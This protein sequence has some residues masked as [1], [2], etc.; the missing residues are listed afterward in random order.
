M[1]TWSF[2]STSEEETERLGEFV[3]QSLQP[4]CVVT[5]S[6]N[7]GAGKTRLVQAIAAGLGADR[8]TVNS[9]TFVL[10]QEYAG[11]MPIYHFDTYRL[12]DVDEF[13]ALGADELLAGDGVCLIEWGERVAEILPDDRLEITIETTGPMS[14]RFRFDARGP[15]SERALAALRESAS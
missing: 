4:G 11:R 3:A 2:D 15:R 12:G 5:L 13:L 14:R 9:P 8:A 7:L 10:I 6:G 1:T